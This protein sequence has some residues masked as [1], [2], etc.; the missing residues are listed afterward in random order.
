MPMFALALGSVAHHHS[1]SV[2]GIFNALVAIGTLLIISAT[3]VVIHVASIPNRRITYGVPVSAR[4]INRS[5]IDAVPRSDL[6]ILWRDA[7]IADPHVLEVALSYRGRKI[8]RSD[9][10]NEGQPFCIDVGVRIRELIKADFDPHEEPCP[11][12]E[13]TATALRI[14]PGLFRKHQAMTFVILTDGPCGRLSDVNPLDAKVKAQPVTRYQPREDPGLLR[15]DMVK[16]VVT[17]AIVLFII[18]Y[19]ATQPAGAA[20]AVHHAYNG[21][22]DA[23]TSLAT[24]VNSL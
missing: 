9:D 18:F 10:F 12:V 8:L 16:R 13:A 22:H 17:W 3:Y 2:E 1:V 23:A 6:H 5:V 21:L 7:E 4:L 19:I 14:G 24:F 15:F 11:R 20:D